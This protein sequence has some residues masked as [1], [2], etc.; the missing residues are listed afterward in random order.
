M[1]IGDV[2]IGVRL[3]LGFGV[4]LVLLAGL[5]LYQ[6]RAMRGLGELQQ[7]EAK[8]AWGAVEIE[9]IDSRLENFYS[10]VGDALI[11][12]DI[13]D[14]RNRLARHKALAERDMTTL[15][16]LSKS[17]AELLA[18]D[19]F[20]QNYRQYIRFVEQD[21][22]FSFDK[23][24]ADPS[25][26]AA[27]NSRAGE[28]RAQ[29]MEP[30]KILVDRLVLD[31]Q[32]ADADFAAKHKELLAATAAGAGGAVLLAF[33]VATGISMSIVR[34]VSKAA[35][36][37]G[38]IAAGN[39]GAELA[40]RQRDEVGVLAEAMR[41]IPATLSGV[42]QDLDAMSESIAKGRLTARSD[43][44]QYSGAYAS[45]LSDANAMADAMLGFLDTV[46]TPVMTVDTEFSIQYMNKAGLAAGLSS[47]EV[48]RG[49]RCSDFFRTGDCGTDA[50][51]CRRAMDDR[52]PSDSTTHAHPD[53][54]DLEIA[55]SAVPILDR[56][57]EVAGALEVVLDQTEIVRTQRRM[58]S[59]AE[60][61]DAISQHLG[62]AAEELSAQV[63][64]VSDGAQVQSERMTET[65]T[66]M[67]EMN[68]TVMEVARNASN[69]AQNS[70][71]ARGEAEK[72]A[73]VVRDAIAAIDDV[74]TLAHTLSEAM[75]ALDGKAE[76]IGKI[77]NVIED[78]A[79]QTNLLAL[80][81]A[82]EAARAG[83]AG[84]GFAVVA[85]EVRKLAEKTMNATKEV[86]DSIAVIQG[87]ARDNVRGMGQATEA[88][89]RA[90]DLAAQSGQALAAIVEL[91]ETSARQVEGIATASEEQSA[92]SEQINGAV[93]QVNDIGRETSQGMTQAAVAVR[94][95]SSM[96]QELQGLI[97]ELVPSRGQI[98]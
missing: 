35:V 95:L 54:G 27:L 73:E 41:A 68:V 44:G 98:V 66:A 19:R 70:S 78:I 46:P 13:R 20:T 77:M 80:N 53:G 15:R 85:D 28:L 65:A 14:A 8:E 25:Q 58:Q 5:S 6:W 21:I 92:A 69:A 76:A 57:G 3:G 61:A 84:R 9:R 36:Y 2:K 45:L 75:Q 79:D 93:T 43:P 26:L 87:A 51:A 48:A 60:R 33:L 30:L 88:V 18:A 81:A 47:L 40:V 90:T 94:E 96:S 91:V 39:F 82:I 22:L 10:L 24:E 74:R 23:I 12:R 1:G 62:S 42:T 52:V 59:I 86:G 4:V 38:E 63:E 29:T 16:T 72:G 83:D 55:Y 37:A 49:T 32:K 97:R 31:M 71:R 17:D 67:D 89:Q 50:C 56:S 11:H 34:P 64:Q 7:A